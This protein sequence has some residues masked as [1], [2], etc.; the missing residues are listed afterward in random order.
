MQYFLFKLNFPRPTFVTDMTEEEI[1][2]VG[3]HKVYWDD[4]MA[5]GNILVFGP[6]H[7]PQGPWG[8]GIVK[9]EDMAMAQSFADND[10]FVTANAGF[11]M[12]IMPMTQ[13][14]EATH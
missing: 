4:L 6:V 8:L 11:H 1:A 12:E 2:L 5:K 10:P 3:A 7:D 14:T 13:V 9:A